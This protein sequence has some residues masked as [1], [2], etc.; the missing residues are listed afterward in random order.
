MLPDPPPPR[1]KLSGQMF[2]ATKREISRRCR[3]TTGFQSKRESR[4]FFEVQPVLYSPCLQ[5]SVQT[6]A[7]ADSILDT[8]A[9]KLMP[10]KEI[11]G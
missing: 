2:R 10:L 11:F 5:G 7:A 9:F 6:T 4:A 1:A 3:Q 8:V